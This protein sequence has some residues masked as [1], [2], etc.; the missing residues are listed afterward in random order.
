MAASFDAGRCAEQI[1]SAW[2]SQRWITEQER[3][4]FTPP[5]LASVYHVH[6]AILRSP[7]ISQLGGLAG[8]K[9][10]GI[11]AAMLAD[12]SPAPAVYGPLVGKWIVPETSASLSISRLQ[13]F[14]VE[15]EFGF[16]MKATPTPRCSDELLSE[17]DVWAAV[18][19]IELCIEVV[20]RRHTISDATSLENLADAS[21]AAAVVCGMNWPVDTP[22]CPTPAILQACQASI[23]V[24]GVE[25]AAGGG[26]KNPLGS[27]VASLT[28]CANHLLTRGL[29]LEPGQLVIAGACCKTREWSSGDEIVANFGDLGQVRVC[30]L[31]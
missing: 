3:A 5:D 7:Q 9:Q 16:R 26:E 18:S 10:G 24:N 30:M 2:V 4:S 1:L 22:N 19:H 23:S 13:L 31:P 15:A 28:W 8:W 29:C 14:G 11:G 27:P 25:K 12:G 6:D 20:G 17:A 21:C